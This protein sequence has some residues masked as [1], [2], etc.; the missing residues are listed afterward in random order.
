MNPKAWISV[1]LITGLMIFVAV[2]ITG[3]ASLTP[4]PVALPVASSCV[5]ANLGTEPA[6]ID[7]DEAL[8]AAAA[9]EDRYQMVVAGRVQRIARL[10]EVEPV[11][12]ACR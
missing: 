4:Q 10:R 12:T 3:C 2:L 11:V 1:T 8:R 7:T 5:P 6:Y 9:P